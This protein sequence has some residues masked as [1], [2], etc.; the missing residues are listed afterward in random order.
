MKL[1]IVGSIN[2]DVYTQ[3][4]KMPSLGET[5]NGYNAT[6]Y[7]GGKG[8]NQAI[9][10]HKFGSDIK[11]IGACGNDK[12]YD[13]LLVYFNEMNFENHNIIQKD[14][15]TGIANIFTTDDDNF[16]ILN[17]G[18]N[19]KLT[20]NEIIESLDDEVEYILIQNEINPTVTIDLI[21][22]CYKKGIK[23]I[24]NPAPVLGIESEVI[25]MIDYFIVNEVEF[26]TIFNKSLEEELINQ[27]GKL[28]VTLGANGVAFYDNGQIKKVDSFDVDVKDTTGAGDTFAGIFSANIAQG[29]NITKA[30]SYA[31]AGS[32]F[33]VQEVSAHKGMKSKEEIKKVINGKG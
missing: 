31:N 10:C 9:A 23:I 8:L 21:N 11:F 13:E 17:Q 16:I 14:I 20:L 7:F 4:S 1:A 25:E 5:I 27:N 24:Y 15:E 32:S 22:Y 29:E 30:V 33:V 3:I 12:Y 2:V 28:I 26:E 6:K 19:Y 18:A